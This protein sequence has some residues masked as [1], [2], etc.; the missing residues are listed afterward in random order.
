MTPQEVLHLQ[1]AIGNRGVGLLLERSKQNADSARSGP[2]AQRTPS[3][4]AF[5]PPGKQTDFNLQ[6]CWPA[7]AL[8][9]IARGKFKL[10]GGLKFGKMARK[11]QI[12]VY[13]WDKRHASSVAFFPRSYFSPAVL[14]VYPNTSVKLVSI[15]IPKHITHRIKAGV[16]VNGVL[17][18]RFN[19]C[20][21]P[22]V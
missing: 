2:V 3:I 17:I 13:T 16:I 4:R 18:R 6:K 8:R 21:L 14:T 10:F 1:S 22:M 15:N 7:G 9:I 12:A 20:G 11:S 5:T 19:I